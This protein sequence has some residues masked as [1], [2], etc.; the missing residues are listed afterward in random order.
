M[1][2]L[3]GRFFLGIL[4]AIL[5]A[6]Q[7]PFVYAQGT[8]SSGGVDVDGSWFV[9]EGL[10]KGDYFEY[11]FCHLDLN[12]CAPITMKF[13]IRGEVQKGTETLWD[14]VVVIEDGNRIEKGSMELGKTA[15]E[16]V[17]QSENLIDY[18]RAFKSSIAWLSAFATGNTDSHIH[19]PKEFRD[20]AWG[21]IGAIG[22]AQLIPVRAE[23][24]SVPA[25][26]YESVVVGWYSGENNRIW[27]VDDFPFP[28]KALAY[29]WV[30]T[31]IAPVQYEFEL[32]EYEEGVMIDPFSD[33]VSDVDKA[34]QLGCDT[35]YNNY[36]S[37]TD[38]TN[39]GS[40]FVEYAY[41]PK[42]PKEGCFID[43]KID[44]K[45]K[46]NQN[47]FL[48]EVHF[49]IWVV[50]DKGNK[51]R[52]Y[53][54]DIGRN[55]LFTGFGLTH[56]N[57]PVE[58][59][60]G[61]NRYAIFVYGLGPQNQIPAGD[62]AG[63]VVVDINVAENENIEE[64]S[65]DVD[66]TATKIPSWIKDNAKWWADGVITDSDFISGIQYMIQN[67]IID[68]PETEQKANPTDQSIPSW[69]K[70]NAKW[71]S[72]GI[73]DDDAFVNGIQYLVENGIIVV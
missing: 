18:A 54:E 48:S 17:S 52:S 69:V 27:L 2:V 51:I 61:Q 46:Y 24:V 4:V 19:G 64:P 33:V 32:L 49:D 62:L 21:K 43:W 30:T 67:D 55:N 50:D 14:A 28:V 58:E 31:G 36:V 39:T 68:I 22:G 66:S 60:A 5:F 73:I 63:Y 26:T 47:E 59:S 38:T 8:Q 7:V 53:A 35:N 56:V 57:L 40:M 11:D 6:G 70:N 9:G 3:E 72:E 29:A 10:K 12:N 23:T 13:W 71:W 1:G 15:P 25:G 41:A 37:K 34:K 42:E 20:N 44:F 45:N 16:P 65:P